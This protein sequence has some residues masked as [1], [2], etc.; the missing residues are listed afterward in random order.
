MVSESA[1]LVEKRMTNIHSGDSLVSS[2]TWKGYKKEVQIFQDWMNT[3]FRK[4][5]QPRTVDFGNCL[6]HGHQKDAI[7]CGLYAL[8][9][10]RHLYLGE[11][12]LTPESQRRSRMRYFIEL[13]TVHLDEVST[14]TCAESHE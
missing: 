1:A 10:P 12:L 13:A 7:A 6:P 14:T 11:D 2:T 8:N 3:R 5:S 4:A 9:V